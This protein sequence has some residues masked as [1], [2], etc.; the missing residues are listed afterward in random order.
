MNRRTRRAVENAVNHGLR[1][2]ALVAENLPAIIA[3]LIATGEEALALRLAALHSSVDLQPEEVAIAEAAAA[4]GDQ[5]RAA[6]RLRDM[7]R[8]E[9]AKDGVNSSADLAGLVARLSKEPRS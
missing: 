1:V 4:A 6:A 8:A 2:R 3:A 7:I 5:A 9:L